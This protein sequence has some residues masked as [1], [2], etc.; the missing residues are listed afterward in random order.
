M[1]SGT[2]VAGASRKPEGSRPRLAVGFD[3]D[4]VLI[5]NPFESCV[6]PRFQDLMVGA[7]ALAHLDPAAARQEARR[8]VGL[9]WR[10]RMV[11]G[12]EI[13]AYDWDGIYR[14]VAAELGAEV[15]I[16][17][18]AWVG[19]C[20][21]VAEHIE[22]L[23]GA[24][25]LLAELTA[26]GVR[27]VVIS[28]GY[29]A[30]Q[31]PVLEALGLLPY[32]DALVTPDA[33]GAAKPDPAI[34]RAAGHL[35]YFVGDTLEHDVLGARRARVGAVWLKPGLPSEIAAL[36]PRQRVGH[37]DL[38]SVIASAL[39]L[40]PHGP[41]Q[42]LANPRDCLPDAVVSHLGEVAGLVLAR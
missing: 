24:H 1:S 14:E 4:G 8:R 28:N 42:P 10:R 32:F 7:P 23:P 12:D 25:K 35:D 31:R 29:A 21:L 22:A 5:R 9:A 17:V 27:L 34:F 38:S 39:M 2:E 6:I 15:E 20:C 16:D 11:A 33:V 41:F 26:A 30:Y 37:P 18:A 19:E 36:T 40:S 13:G 3:L